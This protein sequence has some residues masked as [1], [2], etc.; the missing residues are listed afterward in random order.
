MSPGRPAVDR[1]SAME[2]IEATTHRLDP[3]AQSKPA[4][5]PKTPVTPRSTMTTARYLILAVVTLTASF[6]DTLLDI[7]MK[8]LGPVPLSR[9][10]LL[11]GALRSPWIVGGVLLLIG[12]FASYLTALSWADLTY[13][14]PA[15]SLGYAVIAVLSKFWLHEQI[16]I[17]RWFGILLITAGVGFVAGGP[18]LTTGTES[19]GALD[20]GAGIGEAEGA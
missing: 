9:P 2:R 15:T 20:P 13:V 18:A 7:G 14:L 6:G 11:I 3:A 12:F 1:N 19:P 8:Q 10:A 16:S 5:K 17:A 4:R